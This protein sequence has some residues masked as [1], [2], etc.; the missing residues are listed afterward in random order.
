MHVLQ[1]NSVHTALFSS[2]VSIGKTKQLNTILLKLA[3]TF[4]NLKSS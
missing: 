4:E 1:H 3:A 2:S